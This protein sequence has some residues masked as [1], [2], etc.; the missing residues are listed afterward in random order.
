MKRLI[1]WLRSFIPVREVVRETGPIAPE[2][3]EL[4]SKL[5]SSEVF[6]GLLAS[7]VSR[8]IEDL[9]FKLRSMVR[10]GNS[11]AAVQVEASMQVIEDVPQWFH[12]YATLYEQQMRKQR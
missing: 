4:C 11:G 3:L 12:R 5:M 8:E 9:Q 2:E 6:R 1:E 10:S 7:M